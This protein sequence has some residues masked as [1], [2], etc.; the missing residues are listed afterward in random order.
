MMKNWK[1]II[2]CGILLAALFLSSCGDWEPE[3]SN[4][5][6][7]TYDLRGTW[8]TSN[9]SERY[10]GTLVIETN[11]IT[12][13]GF[14]EDQT[15]PPIFGGNDNERP[16]RGLNIGYA[17]NGYSEAGEEKGHGK[18][19]IEYFG[20]WQDGIAYYYYSIGTPNYVNLLKFTFSGRDQIMVR[21]K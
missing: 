8:V 20:E 9:Q 6:H 4:N 10:T 7:F 13:N 1:R 21:Q 18:I 19:F 16:F 2:A 14:G 15:L 17:L 5:K 11:R 12:I 3:S